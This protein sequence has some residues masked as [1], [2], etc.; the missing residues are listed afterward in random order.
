MSWVERDSYWL[1]MAAQ[2]SEE[3]LSLRQGILTASDF[4]AAVGRSKFS[5]PHE[6]ALDRSGVKKKVFS[7]HTIAI[8][9]HGSD[10]EDIAR[11]KYM[12]IRGV[13]V[14]EVGLAVWKDNPYLGASLDGDVRDDSSSSQPPNL[15]PNG[16]PQ[17][18]PNLNQERAERKGGMLEIKCPLRMYRPLKL[19]A[20]GRSLDYPAD[21][22]NY[23]R[24]YP[25]I[26]PTHYAQMQG[27]MAIC[28][29]EWCDYFVYAVEDNLCYLERIP[30]DPDYWNE[31]YDQL[32]HF[33]TTELIP[34]NE[35]FQSEKSS[36]ITI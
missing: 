11:R 14:D 7:D 24:R 3:W 36:L 34:L 22:H 5:T 9:K 13:I 23:N 25:H 20:E 28:N 35:Q 18:T 32:Q 27:C 21:P 16:K 2:G 1:S 15:N 29:K 30:F 19:K 8:M 17:E 31:L 12:D 33:I 4:G 10:T 6:V 26:W